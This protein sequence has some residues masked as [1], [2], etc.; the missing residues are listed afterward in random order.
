[1]KTKIKIAAFYLLAV[2][3]GGCV[4]S[5][6]PLFTENDLICD[7]NLVGNWAENNPKTVWTFTEKD[8]K[9]YRLTYIADGK[10]GTFTAGL[11]TV[12]S[13][14]YLNI[15][16]EDPNLPQNDFYK[17]HLLYMNTFIKVKFID[18]NL[19]MQMMDAD[20]V[21]KLL[22]KNPNLLKH[23]FVGDRLIL[24]ASTKDLQK[25]MRKYSSDKNL[26]I[27]GD[28]GMLHRIRPYKFAGPE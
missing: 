10:S 3:L 27:F 19:T 12:G 6:H 13:E 24:T 26:K 22:K 16:P 20:N 9:T 7:A 2:V 15:Y 25:F 1:M 8:N 4:P 14:R 23:E 17:N 18:P 11:G 5:V 21:K 28:P